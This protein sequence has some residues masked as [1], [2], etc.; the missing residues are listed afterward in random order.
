[1]SSYRLSVVYNHVCICSDLTAILK[2][3]FLP[4]AITPVR[5]ITISYPSVV[6]SARYVSVTIA[7]IGLQ[8]LSGIAFFLGPEVGLWPSGIGGIRSAYLSDS[9]ASCFFVLEK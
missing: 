4:A 9:W 6:Y 1:M 2:A 3:E 8:S 5:Q 7:C